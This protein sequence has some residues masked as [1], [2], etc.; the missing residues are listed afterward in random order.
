MDTPV[1]THSQAHS[2]GRRGLEALRVQRREAL[3]GMS[4]QLRPWQWQ[5]CEHVAVR[6]S[7]FAAFGHDHANAR[8]EH[9]QVRGAHAVKVFAAL[10]GAQWSAAQGLCR[11]A[12]RTG[13][14]QCDSQC[15]FHSC[16][17][18]PQGCVTA[19]VWTTVTADVGTCAQ[20]PTAHDHRVHKTKM[21]LA[22]QGG[23]M[24]RVHVLPDLW[25]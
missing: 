19:H 22:A 4:L 11:R 16:Y 12:P 17:H 2:S 3:A 15:W 18:S 21:V 23:M 6:A 24:L 8:A 13:V 25:H 20:C 7:T 1:A 10:C 5:C 9:F 14:L